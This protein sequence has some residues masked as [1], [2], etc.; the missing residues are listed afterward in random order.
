[1]AVTSYL[2]F[3][4]AAGQATFCF[5]CC[6][7][8]ACATPVHSSAANTTHFSSS[9]APA[10][11]GEGGCPHC[12]KHQKEP[13]PEKSSSPEKEKHN[14]CPCKEHGTALVMLDVFTDHARGWSLEQVFSASL[15]FDGPSELAPVITSLTRP[16]ATTGLRDGPWLSASDLF[17]THHVIRC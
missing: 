7:L 14:R 11:E 17:T 4:F 16:R 10:S 9:K 12:K 13:S 5:F 1:V 8:K 3:A 2:I 15:A 6:T